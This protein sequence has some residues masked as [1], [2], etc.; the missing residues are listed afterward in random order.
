MAVNKPKGAL[1]ENPLSKSIF[2]PTT[3][4]GS[5]STEDAPKAKKSRIKKEE[6]RKKNQESSKVAQS[7]FLDDSDKEKVNLRLSTDMNDWLDD[8]VKQGKRKHG[9]KIPKE[10]WTQAAL[11]LMRALNDDWSEISS[12]DD[13]RSQIELLVSQLRAEEK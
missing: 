2:T 1:G 5:K 9:Q 4:E 11:E 6:S 3:S 7:S 8:L 10:I 13:L 12:V